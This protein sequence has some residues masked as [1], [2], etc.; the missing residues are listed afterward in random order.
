MG[1]EPQA[2][3][4]S[5]ENMELTLGQVNHSIAISLKRIADV[6]MYKFAPASESA[7]WNDRNPDG[8]LK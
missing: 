5:E 8:S 4:N 3:V 2:L 6:L 7:W 1:L